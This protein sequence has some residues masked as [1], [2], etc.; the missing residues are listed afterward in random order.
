VNR[1]KQD[2]TFLK[3]YNAIIEEQTEHRQGIVERVPVRKENNSATHVP[4]MGLF[5]MIE[6]QQSFV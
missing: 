3:E 6:I 4:T 1:F 2:P 5:E